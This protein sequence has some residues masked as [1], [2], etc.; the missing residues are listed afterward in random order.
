MS[1]P[2]TGGASSLSARIARRIALGAA[3]LLALL[4]AGDDLGGAPT[5]PTSEFHFVRMF[6]RDGGRNDQRDQQPNRPAARKHEVG[7]IEGRTRVL[8]QQLE[9]TLA[10]L[11]DPRYARCRNGPYDLAKTPDSSMSALGGGEPKQ[12]RFR[13]Y[14][15]GAARA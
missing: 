6:Y 8:E 11:I 15:N 3:A 4:A 13:A 14:R 10:P 9:Q 7:P 1:S 2:Q 12:V 5:K